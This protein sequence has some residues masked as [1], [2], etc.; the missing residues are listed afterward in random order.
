VIGEALQQCRTWQQEGLR[1]PVAVNV[2]TRNL[3][4][5]DFPIQVKGL[6]DAWGLEPDVLQL[7]ITEGAVL[8]D[9]VRTKGVLEA[10]ADMGIRLAIDDFG[11]GYSSLAYL[12]RLP[13]KEIK[14]DRSFV[15]SMETNEDD[16]TIVRSTI[17]LGRNL[18]LE[19]V[20]E[21]VE[22]ET[23]WNWLREL[24]CTIAQ[25]YHLSRPLPPDELRDWM[26]EAQLS[27]AS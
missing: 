20:A 8:A 25:G 3:L 7:E 22:S 24:G 17:E 10:L 23:V 14:I 4:D 12:T 15:M 21:G 5:V 26:R 6:L 18:G 11:T 9:P 1:M 2:S 13:I 19:V 27:V 16:A